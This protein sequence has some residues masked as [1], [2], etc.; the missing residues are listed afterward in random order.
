MVNLGL[1]SDTDIE[2]P[3]DFIDVEPSS[4][5]CM[6]LGLIQGSATVALESVALPVVSER[7]TGVVSRERCD[8]RSEMDSR[9][10]PE[11]QAMGQINIHGQGHGVDGEKKSWMEI[12]RDYSAFPT[13]SMGRKK[14]IWLARCDRVMGHKAIHHFVFF[15]SS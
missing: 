14:M 11:L 3:R 4:S 9:M 15:P 1:D 12:R 6:G 7:G 5:E 10:E 13:K 2:Y 8:E